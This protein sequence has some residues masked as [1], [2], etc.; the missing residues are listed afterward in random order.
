MIVIGKHQAMAANDLAD[1]VQGLAHSFPIVSRVPFFGVYRRAND[2]G[3]FKAAGLLE[4]GIE[5][6]P[7]PVV[8]CMD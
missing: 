2:I 6:S 7:E 3:R 1:P 8:T 4:D 5:V